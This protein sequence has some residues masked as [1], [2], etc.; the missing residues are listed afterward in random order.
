MTGKDEAEKVPSIAELRAKLTQA[1]PR[2][3]SGWPVIDTI[4]KGL[5]IGRTTAVRGPQQLRLQ[6]LARMAAWAAG[7]GYPTMIASR[8][9][10][11]EELWLAV[12]AGAL[13]LPPRALLDGHE[14]DAWIDDRL[15]VLDL[16]VF[17]DHD[18]P[19][20]VGAEL[21]R[22][23]P[24]V[25]IVDD[26]PASDEYWDAALDPVDRRLDLNIVPRRLG[27]ALV[28]G[29]T[30]METF[31]DW[32]DRAALTI[33]I[34]PD[35]D[36]SRTRISAYEGQSRD[37]RTVLLRDG[38]L[39]K[40]RLDLPMVRHPGITNIWEERRPEALDAF[41]TTLGAEVVAGHWGEP[42]ERDKTVE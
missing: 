15:R 4:T 21:L 6:V 16:R 9:V 27:C 7:D 39:E 41:M 12:G 17:G 10:T 5:P 34:V 29:S 24:R 40:P 42:D 14:H 18:A 33:R 8:A 35:D 36:G 1:Q 13:G 25:L 31:S 32:L 11:T 30:T 20:R 3:G 38:Y 2:I 26:Y 22:A 23:K 19:E 37:S 28:L